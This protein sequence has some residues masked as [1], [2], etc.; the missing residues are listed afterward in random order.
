[1]ND[2]TFKELI[3][4]LGRSDYI[5]TYHS[6][7]YGQSDEKHEQRVKVASHI[8]SFFPDERGHSIKLLSFPG[9]NWAF[10]NMLMLERPRCNFL[11][12]EHSRTVYLKSKSSM[13]FPLM[14]E[15]HKAD[16]HVQDRTMK[17]GNGYITYSRRRSS[18]S[19]GRGLRS[20]RLLLM[21]AETFVTVMH[22]NYGASIQEKKAFF[23]RFFQR[24]SAWL[25]FTGPLT[26]K[27]EN[28]LKHMPMVFGGGDNPLVLT[29]LNGR[30]RFHG[31]HERLARIQEIQPAFVITGH[32]AYTGKGGVSML[33]V[34]GF[35]NNP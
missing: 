30:D 15:W 18:D 26:E 33:T 20:H 23:Q 28:I 4:G 27:V 16:S 13:P 9:V 25:D 14:N 3:A 11:G 1:M 31:I 29:I 24:N 32:D 2:I 10:E 22:T 8:L 7:S 34:Y 17:Y 6:D 35:I 21:D 12:L 19:N 5:G